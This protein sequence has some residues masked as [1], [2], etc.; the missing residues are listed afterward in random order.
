MQSKTEQKQ[1]FS[2]EI[3][4]H[5]SVGFDE[6]VKN[7]KTVT[8]RNGSVEAFNIDEL[9]AHLTSMC[10]GL[11]MDYINIDIIVGKVSKGLP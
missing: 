11:N 5:D 6:K 10:G 3:H 2:L 1:A 4:A 8:K 9:T 7:Q